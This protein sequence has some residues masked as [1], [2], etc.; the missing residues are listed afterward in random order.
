MRYFERE[1]VKPISRPEKRNLQLLFLLFGLGI[2]AIAPRNPE[3]KDNLGVTIGSFGTLLSL[4]GIGSLV[5]LMFGGHIVHRFG[6]RPILVISS[7][8]MYGALS[9]VP[10]LHHAWIFL[11]L[12]IF[13]GD[14]IHRK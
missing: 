2:M 8:A 1:L 4:G 5:S 3:I 9:I 7:S 13:T 6:P 12:N 10:H 14:V 11:F